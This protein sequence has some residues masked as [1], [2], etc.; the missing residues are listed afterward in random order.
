MTST[1]GLAL[2]VTVVAAG[3]LVN[4]S[5]GPAERTATVSGARLK[6]ISSRVGAKSASLI[7]EATD[8]VAYITTRPDPLTVVV[9]LR[10]VVADGVANSVSADAAS[11]ITAVSLEPTDTATN[12]SRVRVQ[13]AQP[14]AHRVRSDR[15]TIVIDFD[16][17]SSKVG[18]YVL[19][20]ART[21]QGDAAQ[22]TGDPM[23]A[24]GLQNAPTTANAPLVASAAAAVA[25]LAP[26]PSTAAQAI[27]A[28]V[29][30]GLPPQP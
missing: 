8:P 25:L 14:V 4:A 23:Q 2:L 19:P 11:P 28:G 18:P 12:T 24:L 9:D 30:S 10:N 7:I 17:P 21:A 20:P 3:T 29:Q 1:R 26:A 27:P 13:L 15:N 6:T 5:S 22:R 16:K